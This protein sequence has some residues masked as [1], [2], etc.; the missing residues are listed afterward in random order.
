MR[1]ARTE[2]HTKREMQEAPDKKAQRALAVILEDQW[3][4]RCSAG[5]QMQ[6]RCAHHNSIGLPPHRA[7]DT[8]SILAQ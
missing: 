4:Q 7:N 2:I 6:S 5:L 3:R 1:E 8:N